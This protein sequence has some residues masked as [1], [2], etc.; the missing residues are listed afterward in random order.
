ME[1][2]KQ[3][4]PSSLWTNWQVA[5]CEIQE[6]RRRLKTKIK[7]LINYNKLQIKKR[8]V[9]TSFFLLVKN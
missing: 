3:C 8:L 5:L 6:V 4:K 9:Q 1:L 7:R 2:Q